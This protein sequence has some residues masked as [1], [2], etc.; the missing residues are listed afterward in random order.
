MHTN[1]N[2]CTLP[3]THP[4]Q[5]YWPNISQLHTNTQHAHTNTVVYA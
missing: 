1:V 3:G 5:I 4:I 2:T